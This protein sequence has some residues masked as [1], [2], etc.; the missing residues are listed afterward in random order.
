MEAMG[1]FLYSDRTAS[2]KA[3][4][5]RPNYSASPS[6]AGAGAEASTSD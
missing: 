5:Y 1:Y 3:L 6:V 2:L 4:P